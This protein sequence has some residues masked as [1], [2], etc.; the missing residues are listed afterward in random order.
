MKK[1]FRAVTIV[2]AVA[3][4]ISTLVTGCA[5]KVMSPEKV[6]QTYFSELKAGEVTKAADLVIAMDS[7]TSSDSSSS[8]TA[9]SDTMYK[10]MFSKI[11]AK[12]EGKAKISGNT[13]SVKVKITA[14][15]M[16]KIMT[17][18]IS[19]MFSEALSNAFSDSSTSSEDTNSQMTADVTK[20]LSQAD[21]ALTSTEMD[22]QLKKQ[23]GQWK[24]EG[25]KNF[26]DAVTGGL[27]SFSE[28]LSGDTSSSSK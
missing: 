17:N 18:E 22:V 11:D 1:V 9:E 12:A 20:E 16:K 24:I 6:I 8:S 2:C 19:K 3:F 4:S 27:Y 5:K 14:P 26:E 25:T 10:A 15:D 23:N 7:G 13:A 21:V 28:S